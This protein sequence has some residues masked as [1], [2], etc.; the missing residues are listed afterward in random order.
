MADQPTL[1]ERLIAATQQLAGKPSAPQAKATAN[2]TLAALRAVVEL[3]KP[4][5]TYI[6]GGPTGRP[7]CF[8]CDFDGYDGEHPEWPCRTI[9]AIAGELQLEDHRA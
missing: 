5:N 4:Q 6:S 2:K 9:E 1:N 7:L 3:H 8:G